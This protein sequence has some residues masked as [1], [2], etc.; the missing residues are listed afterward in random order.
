MRTIQVRAS[1]AT[2]LFTSGVDEQAVMS[3]TGHSST[4]GVTAYKRMS[5]KLREVTSDVLNQEG[6]P[7]LAVRKQKVE[8]GKENSDISF[9][10]DRDKDKASKSSIDPVFQISRGSHITINIGCP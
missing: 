9:C 2:R 4:D 10:S 5:E 3:V 6:E 7:A 8:E 1:A